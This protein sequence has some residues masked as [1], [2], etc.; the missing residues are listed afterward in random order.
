M[1]TID[2]SQT[3]QLKLAFPGMRS[4]P[5]MPRINAKKSFEIFEI[6]FIKETFSAWIVKQWR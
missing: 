4:S 2:P 6:H 5:Q 1:L 3:N